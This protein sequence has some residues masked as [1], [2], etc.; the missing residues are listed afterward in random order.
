MA[1]VNPS[2]SASRPNTA[3]CN[4]LVCDLSGSSEL[5]CLRLPSR[6]PSST[7]SK[8]AARTM[9]SSESRLNFKSM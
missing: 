8:N 4:V 7:A 3:V 9:T 1:K 2:S 5:S 6:Y